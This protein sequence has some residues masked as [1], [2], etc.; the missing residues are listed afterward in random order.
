M[1]CARYE[2]C[3]GEPDC[4]DQIPI[5]FYLGSSDL[6]PTYRNINNKFSVKYLI[7]LVIIDQY[8]KRYMR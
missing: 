2:V 6:T 4:N 7:C 5:R 3:D 1:L 8:D